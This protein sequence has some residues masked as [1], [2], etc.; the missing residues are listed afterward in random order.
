M[1]AEE[2]NTLFSVDIADPGAKT[3]SEIRTTRSRACCAW[4]LRPAPNVSFYRA[5]KWAD[6]RRERRGVIHFDAAVLNAT[7]NGLTN[8]IPLHRSRSMTKTTCQ[9]DENHLRIDHRS[10]QLGRPSAPAEVIETTFNIF[11]KDYKVR[12]L[13]PPLSAVHIPASQHPSNIR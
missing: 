10:Q 4:S 7:K 6:V 2:A 13:Q 8:D 5:L 9:H 3:P 12:P 11:F 1:S